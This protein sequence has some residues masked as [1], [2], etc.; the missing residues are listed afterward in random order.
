[1]EGQDG[2]YRCPLC[3]QTFVVPDR[4]LPRVFFASASG[5]P[6]VRIVTVAGELEV[7]RCP[8]RQPKD[9]DASG[10]ARAF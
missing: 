2:R 4:F 5:G 6:T 1:M 7:H 3:G 9:L 8:V 10:A